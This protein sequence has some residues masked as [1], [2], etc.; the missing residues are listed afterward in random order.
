MGTS[1]DNLNLG[2]SLDNT[3]T[4]LND[5]EI[6]VSTTFS[7]LIQR[8]LYSN[9]LTLCLFIRWEFSYLLSD[10]VHMDHHIGDLGI[11]NNSYNNSFINVGISIQTFYWKQTES[12]LI[13]IWIRFY[14]NDL[15]LSITTNNTIINLNNLGITISTSCASLDQEIN[16]IYNNL[17]EQVNGKV[18][19]GPFDTL[20]GIY[21]AFQTAQEIS[22]GIQAAWNYAQ[23]QNNY[24]QQTEIST[25]QGQIN[26]A[27]RG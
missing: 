6:N 5:Y 20:L 7:N 11:T 18:D 15:L 1:N 24:S 22:N 27:N 23:G 13:Q 10:S 16:S 4:D 14:N 17:V 19:Q 12:L 8:I 25:L 9:Q 3:I 26:S 21:S 2:I